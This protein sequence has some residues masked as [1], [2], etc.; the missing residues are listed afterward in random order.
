[1]FGRQPRLP[2]DL[3]F[4]LPVSQ[5]V[6]THSEYV[7]KLRS[8]LEKSYQLASENAE[9]SMLK[10]K[11][12]FDRNVTASA[13]EV[14]DRVLV[15]NVRLRGKHKIA[16]KWEPNIYVVIKK[17]GHL[18][19]YT[20]RPE[21]TEKPVRTLHR[22]LLLPCGYLPATSQLQPASVK[23]P[24]KKNLPEPDPDEPLSDDE[25]LLTNW[26]EPC[27]S[28]PVRLVTAVDL[29]RPPPVPEPDLPP[30]IP[31]PATSRELVEP[32]TEQS[33][34]PAMQQTEPE[35]QM[36]HDQPGPEPEH[37]TDSSDESDSDPDS[38]SE[39]FLPVAGTT[40]PT[41]E[42]YSPPESVH[43][44]VNSNEPSDPDVSVSEDAPPARSSTR[45]RRPPER[46]HYAAFGKPLL[47]SMQSFFDDLGTIISFAIMGNDGSRTGTPGLPSSGCPPS[48][49]TGTYMRSGGD[50]VTQ[51][52]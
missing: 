35:P 47:K 20:V 37:E 13:L 6:H 7:Q 21:H 1:M 12:R 10:N 51:V 32:E 50:P 14:G 45:V 8:H 16:D 34:Q 27:T 4:G 26:Y 30:A 40:S 33:E 29:P 48:T 23:R 11:T 38:A 28:E 15:R 41:S 31:S 25:F 9:K 22:D 43:S 49:C 3:V 44:P 42:T 36:Q 5:P 46:L 39:H 18:P 19:V 24:A 17:A 52:T 2:V